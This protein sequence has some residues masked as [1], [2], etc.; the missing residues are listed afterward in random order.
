MS[1]TECVWVTRWS[2]KGKSGRLIGGS[3]AFLQ[4]FLISSTG[5]SHISHRSLLT[6]PVSRAHTAPWRDRLRSIAYAQLREEDANCA[7]P[8]DPLAPLPAPFALYPPS[9]WLRR[10]LTPQ[11]GSAR[12]AA[13]AAVL[14]FRFSLI[15]IRRRFTIT[16]LTDTLAAVKARLSTMAVRLLVALLALAAVDAQQINLVQGE[17]FCE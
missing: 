14:R 12:F 15:V 5:S 3:F 2:A 17:G 16:C 10:F 4:P 6:A 9:S 11:P 1:V 8:E 13:A 7:I